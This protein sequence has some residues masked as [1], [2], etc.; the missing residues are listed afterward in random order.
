VAQVASC[1]SLHLYIRG[2]RI[3]FCLQSPA[4]VN[5]HPGVLGAHLVT[6]GRGDEQT[7]CMVV[8]PVVA[9]EPGTASMLFGLVWRIAAMHGLQA[10]RLVRAV[11]RRDQGDANG[12]PDWV[13]L[14]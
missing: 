13:R 11:E 5:E 4:W 1:K 8:Q 10:V 2:G 7:W 6:A 3:R 12:F 9:V 14:R